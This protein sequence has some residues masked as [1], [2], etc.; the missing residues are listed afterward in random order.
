VAAALRPYAHIY[1]A[2]AGDGSG[3]LDRFL[4]EAGVP[5]AVEQLSR[6]LRASR[7]TVMAEAMAEAL[8]RSLSLATDSP[9]RR[10]LAEMASAEVQTAIEQMRRQMPSV[11]SVN[12]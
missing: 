8:S 12:I 7:E 5:A 10:V 3:L 9:I 1:G 11:S 4:A 6:R 2:P